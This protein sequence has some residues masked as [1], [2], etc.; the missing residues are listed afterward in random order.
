MSCLGFCWQAWLQS[1]VF[2]HTILIPRPPSTVLT[3]AG[4]RGFRAHFSDKVGG[5][6]TKSAL[7]FSK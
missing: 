5:T 1:P 3:F 6:R 4:K 7:P 2:Y